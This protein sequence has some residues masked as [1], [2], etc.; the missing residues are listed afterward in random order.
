MFKIIDCEQGSQEWFSARIGMFTG[1]TASDLHMG[2]TTKGYLGLIAEKAAETF[3]EVSSYEIE[4]A[5]GKQIYSDFKPSIGVNGEYGTLM[6]PMAREYY[7]KKY[8]EEIYTVG[9][10][11][12]D[13][14]PNDVITSPDALFMRKN[15]GV[16][17]K[18]RRSLATHMACLKL[19]TP[20]DFKEMNVK[21]YWQVIHN[22]VV[23]EAEQWDFVSYLPFLKPE[24]VMAC[25]VVNR[26]DVLEDIE[27]HTK[28]LEEAVK[29]KHALLQ[30]Q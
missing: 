2:K 19:R 17:I 12:S 10:C 20:A 28:E 27:N 16:E 23:C 18:C 30:Q 5:T 14:W 22:M 21:E 25:L 26:C 4:Q 9:L 24:H 3:F 7:A 15:G 8:D 11:V 1:S 6:E 13:R 29:K